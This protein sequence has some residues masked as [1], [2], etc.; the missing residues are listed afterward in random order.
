MSIK[1]QKYKKTRQS[2]GRA[3]RKTRKHN[4]WRSFFNL[5]GVAVAGFLFWMIIS[6]ISS[7]GFFAVDKITV[8]GLNY[9]TQEEIIKPMNKAKGL[10]IFRLK[11]EDFEDELKKL[12][13]VKNVRIYREL[14][15][16]LHVIVKER[17]L[18]ALVNTGSS[19]IAV[20]IEGNL[21]APP[22]KG[23]VYDLPIISKSG[24]DNKNLHQ[25]VDFLRAAKTFSPEVYAKI[26]EVKL[27]GK[28]GDIYAF[29]DN[30]AK[31][32]LVGRDNY[33]EKI[34]KLWL[35]MHREEVDFKS[36]ASVDLRFAG[37]VFF[38]RI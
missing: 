22:R 1:I 29:V 34:L 36:F 20:D 18:L 31:P 23:N 24:E 14:P 13:Y 28:Q 12:P 35:L 10:N 8:S 11:A 4:P 6:W 7:T 3:E 9:L 2:F 27:S 32:V 15:S 33:K 25:A 21:V 16:E 5:V 38:T 17:E 37:K 30:S 26:S 19:L